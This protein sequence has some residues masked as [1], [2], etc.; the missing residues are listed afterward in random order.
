MIGW[1]RGHR[2]VLWRGERTEG[3]EKRRRK[4]KKRWKRKWKRKKRMWK[5]M[6]RMEGSWMSKKNDECGKRQSER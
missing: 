4:K 5:R 1:W 3:R 6:K 2:E